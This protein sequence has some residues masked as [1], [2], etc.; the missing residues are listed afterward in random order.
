MRRLLGLLL[1]TVLV[2]TGCATGG[3]S[4]VAP[5]ASAIRELEQKGAAFSYTDNL[6]ESG[7]S[8]AS[9]K[10]AQDRAVGADLNGH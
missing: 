5:V 3:G 6:L 4:D 8:L 10:V 1:A 2:G 7:G 9:G